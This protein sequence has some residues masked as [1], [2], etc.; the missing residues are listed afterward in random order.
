M[1]SKRWVVLG[2]V[3][4]A[5]AAALPLS[6]MAQVKPGATATDVA[7]YAG[8]DRMQKLIDGARKEG[9]ITIYTS[10]QAEDLGAVV[11]AFERKYGIKATLWRASSENVLNRAIQEA[12]AG[13]NTMDIVET[14]GPE[15]ESLHR[16]KVLQ[17]VRSPYLAD[18]IAPAI[19]PHGEWVGT[20]L[21]VFVQAYNT[22]LV[23]K[24]DLPRTW[25]EFAQ[26]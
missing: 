9:A 10:A 19:Q 7:V 25:E 6:G 8:A 1:N 26:P 12:R 4:A 17:A 3:A 16:E 2:W 5:V 24:T 22:R 20:R 14:N 15:L 23:K 11:S 18:L 21:N 13:R